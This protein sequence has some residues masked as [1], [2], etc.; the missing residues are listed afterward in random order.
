MEMKTTRI[1]IALYALL[2]FC[3]IACSQ[4]SKKDG[5]EEH[6]GMKYIFDMVHINP[7]EGATFTIILQPQEIA[8]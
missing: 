3:G 1:R 8:S 7:G 4:S 6:V 5:D 2:A